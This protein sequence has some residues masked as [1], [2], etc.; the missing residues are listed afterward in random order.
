MEHWLLVGLINLLV[1]VVI[2]AFFAWAFAR[3][4]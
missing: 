2:I 1:L 3:D 4:R